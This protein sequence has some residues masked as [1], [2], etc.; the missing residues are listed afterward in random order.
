MEKISKPLRVWCLVGDQRA[1]VEPVERLLGHRAVFRYEA[2]LDLESGPD[3][4]LDVLLCVND[5]PPQVANAIDVARRHGIRSL[6]LQDGILEWRCQYQNPLFGFGGG[7]PQHQPVLTDKIACIGAQSA[8]QIAAWGNEGKVEVVGMPRLDF[9]LGRPQTPRRRPGR[10]ILVMTAKNPGFTP[11]QRETTVRSLKHLKSHLAQLDGIETIWRVARGLVPAL[12]VENRLDNLGGSE[13]TDVIEGVDAVVTTPSTAILECMLL[14]RPVAALDYHN[15]PRFVPTAWTISAQEHIPSVVAE[16][17]DPPGSKI[18][19]Q[20]DC[21][22]DCL[23][24]DGPA[25]PRVAALLFE[26]AGPREGDATLRNGRPPKG[27]DGHRPAF[28]ADLYPGQSVFVVDDVVELQV[29]LARLQK[30]NEMLRLA[31]SQRH[32]L[33]RILSYGSSLVSGLRER[34]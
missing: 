9:L 13:L 8:R 2:E 30:E 25:A 6:S 31:L 26:M 27:S 14:K 20:E 32:P 19:F 4:Q 28:L 17:L 22:A 34:A 5:W 18:A 7:A 24:C 10:K 29:R 16:L 23:R 21:L 3:G 15:V 1:H 12:Q 33:Q 11:E